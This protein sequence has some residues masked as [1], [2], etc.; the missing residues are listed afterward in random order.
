MSLFDKIIT[1]RDTIRDIS[2]PW[3]RRGYNEKLGY[4]IGVQVDDF[5]DALIAAVNI[6]FP[7]VY[8]NETLPILGRERRIRRGRTETDDTYATRLNRWLTDHRRRGGPY[9]LL[10]QI[11]AYY[12]PNNFPIELVYRNG[13]RFS[14]D[15]AGNVTRDTTTWT[16]NSDPPERWAQWIL[17]YHW[18]TDVISTGTWDGEPAT[19]W[20]DPTTV[21][22]SEMSPEDIEDIRLVPRDWNA[23][24][25]FGYVRLVDSS[26]RYLQFA[27]GNG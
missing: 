2:P 12:A 13:K 7:N 19:L 17:I 23:A 14:M 1:F 8:S 11:H 27:I 25:C 26:A 6:R 18:P 21:W 10:A 22:D 16:Y 9:A 15:V 24:H 5:G 4:A 20:D 3:L